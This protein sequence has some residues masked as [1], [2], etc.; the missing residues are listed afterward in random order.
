MISKIEEECELEKEN[1]P[2]S[3]KENNPKF[4]NQP[5]MKSN[6]G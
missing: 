4:K 1:M 6:F 3:S 2:Q 5:Q